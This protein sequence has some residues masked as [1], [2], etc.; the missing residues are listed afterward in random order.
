MLGLA[1]RYPAAMQVNQI[2]M[3]SCLRID[4]K[5]VQPQVLDC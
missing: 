5:R 1:S 4:S 3:S 2:P